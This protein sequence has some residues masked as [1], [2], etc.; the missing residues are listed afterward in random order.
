MQKWM[1]GSCKMYWKTLVNHFSGNA[2]FGN[3]P[4]IDDNSLQ[5]FLILLFPELGLYIKIR[6][7]IRENVKHCIIVT[8]SETNTSIFWLN[9]VYLSGDWFCRS[10]SLSCAIISVEY[11]YCFGGLALA[12]SQTPAQPLVHSPPLGTLGEKIGLKS[13]WDKIKTGYCLPHTERN[14]FILLSFKIDLDRKKAR[15]FFPTF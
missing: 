4:A 2:L 12:K 6:V 5:V 15:H 10:L 1:I 11:F 13:F 3:K 9:S 8:N 14:L 7:I